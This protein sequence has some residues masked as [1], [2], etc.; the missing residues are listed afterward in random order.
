[1]ASYEDDYGYSGANSLD[2]W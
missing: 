1:C 2:V